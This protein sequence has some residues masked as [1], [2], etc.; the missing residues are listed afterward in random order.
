MEDDDRNDAV[1]LVR[2]WLAPSL[3]A[4]LLLHGLRLVVDRD[5]RSAGPGRGGGLRRDRSA[6]V[7]QP[8]IAAGEPGQN[9]AGDHAEHLRVLWSLRLSL[10][11]HQD[12]LAGLAAL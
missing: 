10:H 8:E 11:P 6:L 9:S 5:H 4:A 7:D 12:G 3:H 2:G 1:R